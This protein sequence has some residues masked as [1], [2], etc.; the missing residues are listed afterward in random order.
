M[1]PNGFQHQDSFLKN[2]DAETCEQRKKDVFVIFDKKMNK[3]FA[4][5]KAKG[6]GMLVLYPKHC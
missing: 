1:K 2:V 3:L 4:S 5:K 6:L